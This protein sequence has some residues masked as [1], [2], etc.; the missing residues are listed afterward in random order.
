MT[1]TNNNNEGIEKEIEKLTLNTTEN[2]IIYYPKLPIW[3]QFQNANFPTGEIL[4]Y[5]K[6]KNQEKYNKYISN[7]K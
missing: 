2:E 6:P 1:E 3:E 4:E 5:Q 7:Y